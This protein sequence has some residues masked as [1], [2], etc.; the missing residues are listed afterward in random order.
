MK[1]IVWISALAVLFLSSCSSVHTNT[2]YDKNVDFSQYKTFSF[3]QKGL[4]SLKL[5][6]LDKSRVTNSIIY[7]LEQKG[8]KMV[9]SGDLLVNITVSYKDRTDI[10]Q[11]YSPGYGGYGGYG[12]WGYGNYPRTYSR[13][14]TEGRMLVDLVDKNRNKL[15]WQGYVSGMDL[16]Q[17]RNKD[18]MIPKTID[19][20]FYNFPPKRK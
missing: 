15:V 4:D 10:N 14:Y 6:D 20:L 7:N 13:S 5:N 1:Q 9:P 18:Q 19:K 11:T 3:Y 17:I 16:D 2:D 8:L 12:G